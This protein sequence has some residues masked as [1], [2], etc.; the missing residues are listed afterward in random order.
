MFSEGL[1]TPGRRM[2]DTVVALTLVLVLGWLILRTVVA[3]QPGG[4]DA[5]L[6]EQL[7][8]GAPGLSLRPGSAA[9]EGQVDRARLH[10]AVNFAP[11]SGRAA[12]EVA[13]TASVD[14]EHARALRLLINA[15]DRDPRNAVVRLQLV[16]EYFVAGRPD[17]AISEADIAMRLQPGYVAQLAPLLPAM[18]STP[19]ALAAL[20]AAVRRGPR[21]SGVLLQ[22]KALYN[23]SPALLFA[24]IDE[25]RTD[26]PDEAQTLRQSA[27]LR[28]LLAGGQ[29]DAAFLAFANFLPKG[30]NP[31]ARLVYDGD[32]AGRPGPPPFNWTLV[33][34]QVDSATIGDG[35]LTLQFFSDRRSTMASEIVQ[36][37]PGRYRLTTVAAAPNG[38]A[39]ADAARW[40]VRC[41]PGA[42]SDTTLA[43]LPLGALTSDPAQVTLDFVVP[44]GA[45]A[46]QTLSLV[47]N[48]QTE[49]ADVTL[50]IGSV[51]IERLP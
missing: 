30:T 2:L 33:E 44:A 10:A 34:G 28:R 15:R 11:L 23:T 51:G 46:A 5:H 50:R 45:C 22:N 3:A 38:D 20:R 40:V 1:R 27:Y 25:T 41:G 39:A 29:V 16:G 6:L 31:A 9:G 48:R 18:A 14:G 24:I 21:W 42:T 17:L 8:P 19:A 4:I 32:F 47:T 43:T 12:S 26:N 7:A 49:P 37:T 36:L 35:G 13:A